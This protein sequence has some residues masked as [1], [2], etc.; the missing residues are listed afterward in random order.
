MPFE[1]ASREFA[2]AVPPHALIAMNRGDMDA[3][4]R[5]LAP[6]MPLSD[7]E[8]IADEMEARREDLVGAC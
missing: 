8:L 1:T 7:R 4:I 5:Q 2:R 3:L 6:C